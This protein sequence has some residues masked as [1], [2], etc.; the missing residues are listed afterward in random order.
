MILSKFPPSNICCHNAL[1]KFLVV[2]FGRIWFEDLESWICTLW[3]H[4][5][6]IGIITTL[7]YKKSDHVPSLLKIF[8]WHD[9]CRPVHGHRMRLTQP[10]HLVSWGSVMLW[11]QTAP[12][13][14][15]LM[16]TEACLSVIQRFHCKSVEALFRVIFILWLMLKEWALL[17]CVSQRKRESF[18]QKQHFCSHVFAKASHVTTPEFSKVAPGKNITGRMATYDIN[19]V[20]VIFLQKGCQVFWILM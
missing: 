11:Q 7:K 15:W 16:T 9:V 19:T 4:T 1:I 13:S 18:V 17:W 14:Q 12:E 3:W 6:L 2:V 5:T 20:K 10:H 8:Q